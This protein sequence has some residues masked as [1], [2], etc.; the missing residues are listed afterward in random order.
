LNLLF[1]NLLLFT[2]TKS[3]VDTLSRGN[4]TKDGKKARFLGRLSKLI[5]FK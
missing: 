5:G 4:E 3:G 1:L 2:R